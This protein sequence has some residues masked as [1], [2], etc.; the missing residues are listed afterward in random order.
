MDNETL[1]DLGMQRVSVYRA[2]PPLQIYTYRNLVGALGIHTLRVWFS[3]HTGQVNICEPATLRRAWASR[4]AVR[5]ALIALIVDR[6]MLDPG[7]RAID[8]GA[9]CAMPIGTASLSPIE[10]RLS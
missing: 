7:T 6:R 4:L 10:P 8:G 9:V 5:V 1:F 2:D 3:N